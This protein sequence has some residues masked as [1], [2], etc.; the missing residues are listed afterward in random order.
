MSKPGDY[1]RANK[2]GQ[3]HIIL[4]CSGEG[5]PTCKAP[6]CLYGAEPCPNDD[7]RGFK[8]EGFPCNYCGTKSDGDQDNN[9]IIHYDY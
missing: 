6:E 1:C 5:R 4:G 7:C 2:D 9:L 3:G 8:P